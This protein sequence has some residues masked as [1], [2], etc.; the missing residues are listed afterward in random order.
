MADE[1][2]REPEVLRI[3]ESIEPGQFTLSY[4]HRFDESAATPADLTVDWDGGETATWIHDVSE[5]T[6]SM[7]VASS[8][9]CY[10]WVGWGG[11]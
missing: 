9:P 10:G 6:E 11:R 8:V 1:D 3:P 5:Y 7:S 4:L 2:D